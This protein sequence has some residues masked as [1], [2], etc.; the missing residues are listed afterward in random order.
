MAQRHLARFYNRFY[1]RTDTLLRDFTVMSP[2]PNITIGE[3]ALDTLIMNSRSSLVNRLFHLWGEFCR[4]VVVAS[5]LG[6]YT[7]LGGQVVTRAP[8]IKRQ[9]DIPWAIGENR[10]VGIG[11]RWEDP[12]W[13]SVRV[14]RLQLANAQQVKLGIA[15]A[16]F[17]QFRPVRHFVIHSNAHTRAEFEVI[18]KSFSL[19]DVEPD[20]LL[21][22]RLRGG[23]TVLERWIR[24]FQVSAYNAVM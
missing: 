22:H 20:D 24:E 19:F 9:S 7:T 13:T 21:L 3:T 1:T 23:G 5:A 17:Y 14:D 10:I 18:A 16:P 11:L 15:A 6:G 4:S 12:Q 8:N 2:C